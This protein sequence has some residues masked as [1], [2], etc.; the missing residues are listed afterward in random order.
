MVIASLTK[1][2]DFL[3][4]LVEPGIFFVLHQHGA[5]YLFCSFGTGTNWYLY[6]FSLRECT[7][8]TNLII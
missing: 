5:F 2:L 4:I 1:G 6:L 8:G 7:C 3:A